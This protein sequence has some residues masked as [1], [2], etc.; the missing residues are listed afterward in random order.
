MT[1]T[2]W[3]VR[4]RGFEEERAGREDALDRWGQLEARGIAAEVLDVTAEGEERPVILA[5]RL[6]GITD[7]TCP[8]GFGAPATE[9]TPRNQARSPSG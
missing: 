2:A 1:R 4:W 7:G 8:T 9:L 6:D 3:I 5:A